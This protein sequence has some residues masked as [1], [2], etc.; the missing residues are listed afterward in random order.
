MIRRPPRST[1][2]P[3]TTLFRSPPQPE[4]SGQRLPLG[5]PG[6]G[7]A[8][9]F[10]LGVAEED[11]EQPGDLS[12]A[13]EDGDRRDRVVLVRHRGGAAAPRGPGGDGGVDPP[14]LGR[15][16]WR[17]WVMASIGGT[18]ALADL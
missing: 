8:L 10:V 4:Q 13:A 11:A 1:L 7:R 17:P 18:A 2:F 14:V 16:R 5:V 15:F 3:Y 12:G 9:Q 6:S